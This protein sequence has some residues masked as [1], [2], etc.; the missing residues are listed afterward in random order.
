MSIPTKTPSQ[1]GRGAIA[2]EG[3]YLH[4]KCSLR[5]WRG[6]CLVVLP[7][8]HSFFF[9]HPEGGASELANALK[10]RNRLAVVAPRPT[11]RQT[12]FSDRIAA[13]AELGARMLAAERC[14]IAVTASGA[15]AD[16]VVCAPRGDSRWDKVVNAVLA[17]LDNR[18]GD[19]AAGYGMKRAPGAQGSIE[20]I[21]R[22]ALSAREIDDD[23]VAVLRA[24]AQP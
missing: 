11:S 6:L 23:Y 19:A 5:N 2:R 18:L 15:G 16:E 10:Q 1:V 9:C 7:L 14:A 12:S 24:Q 13:I 17:A 20:S 8:E 21:E 4:I 3:V 22:V